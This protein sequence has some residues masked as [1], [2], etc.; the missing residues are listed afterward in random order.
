MTVTKQP[1]LYKYT[2][3]GQIQQWQIF[4]QGDSF[5]TEE[6]IQGGTITK[7]KP[8]VCKA[9]NVG[10]ANATTPDEQA[11]AEAKAKW[12]KKVDG[13]YNEVLTSGSKFFEPMLAK[14]YEEDKIDWSKKVWIQPKLDGLRCINNGE[15]LKSR[16]GK[17]FYASHLLHGDESVLLDGELYNHQFKNDFN[18][19]S[20]LFKREEK[21]RTPQQ[22][23]DCMLKGQMWVYD[24]PSHKG[25][26]SDRYEALKEWVENQVNPQFV[27]VPTFRVKS[28]KE[29]KAKHKEFMKQGY[30]GS[31]I[32]LDE[33]YETKRS[34]NLLKFKDWQDKEFKIIG[35]EEGEGGRAGTIGAFILDFPEGQGAKTFKSNVKGKFD[36]VTKI[37]ENRDSYIGKDATVEFQ[38]YTPVKIKKGVPEGGVPRF[39]YVIKIDRDSYE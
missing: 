39:P 8:T 10:R 3:K 30:E 19:I 9:K 4:S 11:L 5:W 1:I 18:A 2:Q 25:I 15:S 22:A 26:F 21:N 37:W 17:D 35:F 6:G 20:G 27:L 14:E 33:K 31:I 34:K 28:H 23:T 13:G 12:Q 38:N 36:Y 7:S 32:R 29:V 16:N 24:M